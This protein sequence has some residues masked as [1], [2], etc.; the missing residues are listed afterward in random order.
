MEFDE[1]SLAAAIRAAGIAEG[2]AAVNMATDLLTRIVAP[3]PEMVC[4]AALER[5]AAQSEFDGYFADL[6]AEL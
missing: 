6:G 4:E 2:R 3:T 5:A 1:F